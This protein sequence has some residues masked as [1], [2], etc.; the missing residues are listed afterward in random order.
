MQCAIQGGKNEPVM[1]PISFIF[2]YVCINLFIY[3]FKLQISLDKR[4]Y[5][6]SLGKNNFNIY[7]FSTKFTVFYV[8]NSNFYGPYSSSF[9]CWNSN[10]NS[11]YFDK[12]F[13][14]KHDDSLSKGENQFDLYNFQL[15]L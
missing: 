11:I 9:D 2:I 3:L 5:H 14:R 12:T 10:H 6:Q 15:K 4:F 7:I 8:H 1:N 13:G